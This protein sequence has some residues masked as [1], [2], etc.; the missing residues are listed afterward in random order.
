M[1][2]GLIYLLIILILCFLNIKIK[3]ALQIIKIA[4]LLGKNKVSIYDYGGGSG[5]FLNNIKKIIDLIN[6]ELE[7]NISSYDIK[8]Y[9]KYNKSSTKLSNNHF[10]I[11][12][13]SYCLH[14]IREKSHQRILKYIISHSRYSIFIEDNRTFLNQC[15]H[16]IHNSVYISDKK[17]ILQQFY[18]KKEF[19]EKISDFNCEIILS[20]KYYFKL[21]S[22]QSNNILNSFYYN[23][24]FIII[25]KN[26]NNWI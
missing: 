19:T 20:K 12:I 11:I 4:K 8:C 16:H 22:Q 14:H 7:L 5:L 18:T 23:P 2:Q 3:I 1:K 17:T 15:I 24:T 25:T 26:L 21:P 6:P 13:C 10:D 9:N